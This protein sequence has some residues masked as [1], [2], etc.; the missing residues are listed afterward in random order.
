[1]AFAGGFLFRYRSWRR[2]MRFA[3]IATVALIS[4]ST[5]KAETRELAV[6]Q[7]HAT[8]WEVLPGYLFF[9]ALLSV[10]I[11]E[12]VANAARKYGL[13]QY[14]LELMLRVLV[15]EVIPLLTALFV[16]LRTGAAIGSEVALMTV[17]GELVEEQESGE[18]PLENEIVPRI[19]GAALSVVSLTTLACAIAVWLAYTAT[20]G[21]SDAGLPEF[22]R[23]VADVF[24]VQVLVGFVLKCM[25]FGLAVA[26][27]PVATGLEAERGEVKSAPHA[28]LGGLVTLFFVIG[29]IEVLSLAGK[30]F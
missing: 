21:F 7:I 19:A 29:V 11:I 2:L 10:V 15:L 6:R 9:S 3:G 30:Y 8:A 23:V 28:V 1:M 26:L 24:D 13:G 5:Y 17:S 14:A 18:R 20:Y 25:L 4:P 27:I 12:I 16:A 22:E